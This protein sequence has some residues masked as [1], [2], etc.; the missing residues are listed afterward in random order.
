MATFGHIPWEWA[1]R[2]W[3]G[4]ARS[5]DKLVGHL[6]LTTRRVAAG[7]AQL[8]V[9]GIGGVT[10]HETWRRRGVAL[11]LLAS[12]AS[13][14]R[15]RLTCSFGL[16]IC[17]AEVASVYEQAGWR[18]TAAPTRFEQ[19]SGPVTYPGVTMVLPLVQDAAWPKGDIDLRG[20]PW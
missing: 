7:T 6:S 20:L 3:Y 17:R 2:R 16:L 9:V 8:E 4:L 15:E 19:P 1:E 5:D 10:T 14:M 18:T 12:A 13:F 11:A